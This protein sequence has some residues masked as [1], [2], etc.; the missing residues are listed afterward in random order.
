LAVIVDGG[1]KRFLELLR[2][3][4]DPDTVGP[5]FVPRVRHLHGRVDL[6]RLYAPVY[7]VRPWQCPERVSMAD[8]VVSS[9]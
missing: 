6:V 2:L 9:R 7:A 3:I 1:G 8:A 4:E 5:V